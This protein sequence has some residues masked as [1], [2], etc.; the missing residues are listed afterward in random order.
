MWEWEEDSLLYSVTEYTATKDIFQAVCNEIG[1]Y[2]HSKGMKYTKSNRKL[3]WKGNKVCCEFGFWTSHSN[4]RGKW[5]NLEIVTSIFSLH[6][7]SSKQKLLIDIDIRP[8]NF[9]VYKINY[10]KFYEIINYI[11]N[12]LEFVNS[13]ETKD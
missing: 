1:R 13:L 9:D 4:M 11:D 12:V 10:D 5:V 2:Y 3:K 8:E 7:S 6:K